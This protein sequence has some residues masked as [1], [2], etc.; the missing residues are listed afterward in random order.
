M[1]SN[2]TGPWEGLRF[3]GAA[4]V[5]DPDGVIRARPGARPGIAVAQ[6]DPPADRAAML[7][8]VD[9]LADRRPRAYGA[10]VAPDSLLDSATSG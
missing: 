2:Q 4:K 10:H 1:A 7:L 3:L 6:V 5:V 9:H 8:D